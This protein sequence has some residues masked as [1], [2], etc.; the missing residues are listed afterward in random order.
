ML[1]AVIEPDRRRISSRVRAVAPGNSAAMRYASTGYPI[2]MEDFYRTAMGKT[3]R[4]E[5]S[6]DGA[7]TVNVL[8]DGVWERAPLGMIGL[9][10]APMTRRLTAREVNSLPA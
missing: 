3:I 1:I 5:E 6:D 7:L 2:D 8:R 4:V 9:R 10:L